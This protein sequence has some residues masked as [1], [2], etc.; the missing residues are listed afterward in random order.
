[1][2]EGNIGGKD[3]SGEKKFGLGGS[4]GKGALPSGT[5]MQW[6]SLPRGRGGSEELTFRRGQV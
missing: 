4:K 5:D 1:M 3:V 2:K 6:E